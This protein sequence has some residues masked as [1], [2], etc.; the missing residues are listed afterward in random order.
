MIAKTAIDVIRRGQTRG[1]QPLLR[2]SRVSFLYNATGPVPMRILTPRNGTEW[3][4]TCDD[5]WARPIGDNR[6]YR[7][8]GHLTVNCREIGR[9]RYP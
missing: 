2:L 5:Q 3:A 7:R 9:G 8:G 1:K 4:H 6:P